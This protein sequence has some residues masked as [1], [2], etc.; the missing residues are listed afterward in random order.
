MLTKYKLVSF[1]VN[2]LLFESGSS[3]LMRTT[4]VEQFKTI[5]GMSIMQKEREILG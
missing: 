2:A 5:P 1:N 4:Q 3:V